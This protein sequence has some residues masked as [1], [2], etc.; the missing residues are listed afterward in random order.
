MIFK[1]KRS[2]DYCERYST[3]DEALEG[4]NKAIEWVKDGCKDD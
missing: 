3:W 1:A 4:H 2:L